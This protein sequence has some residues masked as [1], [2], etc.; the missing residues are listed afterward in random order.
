MPASITDDIVPGRSSPTGI[1]T[2]IRLFQFRRCWRGTLAGPKRLVEHSLVGFYP[3]AGD[4]ATDLT[5]AIDLRVSDR[6]PSPR[7]VRTTM[8]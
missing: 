1:G 6:L 2:P 4:P 8:L 5:S 7:A 3:T